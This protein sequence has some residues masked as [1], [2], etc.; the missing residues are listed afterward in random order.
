MPHQS[1]RWRPLGPSCIDGGGHGP[2]GVSREPPLYQAHERSAR[3][4]QRVRRASEGEHLVP[5]GVVIPH[6]SSSKRLIRASEGLSAVSP[7][8]IY[9]VSGS[10][11]RPIRIVALTCDRSRVRQD[12]RVSHEL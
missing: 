4:G 11:G 10:M 3:P 6:G 12:H 2:K 8:W 5:H 1:R 9:N 7:D